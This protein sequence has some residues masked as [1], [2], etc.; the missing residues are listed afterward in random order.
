MIVKKEP[1]KT[2]SLLIAVLTITLACSGC[3]QPTVVMERNNI[4]D[5]THPEYVPGS[6]QNL[7]ISSDSSGLIYLTWDDRATL[8]DGYLVEKAFED[9]SQFEII[10]SLPPDT[11]SYTDSSRIVD[12]NTFFRISSY[13]EQGDQLRRFAHPIQK[14]TI[15]KLKRSSL[16]EIPDNQRHILSWSVESNFLNS[17]ELEI[18]QEDKPQTVISKSGLELSGEYIDNLEEIRFSDR[19][20]ILRGILETGQN[21]QIAFEELFKSDIDELYSPTNAY[22]EIINEMQLRV[23]W[24][25]RAFF[26]DKI[27][28]YKKDPSGDINLLTTLPPETKKYTDFS[29]V[30]EQNLYHIISVVGDSKSS[31]EP[32]SKAFKWESIPTASVSETNLANTNVLELSLTAEPAEIIDEFIL[33]R[34]DHQA[35]EKKEIA[36]LPGG[37]ESYRDYTIEPGLKYSYTLESSSTLALSQKSDIKDVEALLSDQFNKTK[38]YDLGY[39]G[40]AR[41]GRNLQLVNNNQYALLRTGKCNSTGEKLKIVNLHTDELHELAFPGINYINDY[42]HNPTE[43]T[44]LA[45]FSNKMTEVGF[46]GGELVREADELY[47]GND[48]LR[49]LSVQSADLHNNGRNIYVNTNNGSILNIDYESLNI[50]AIRKGGGSTTGARD[51]QLSNN[52]SLLISNDLVNYVVDPEQNEIIQ[53]FGDPV[54]ENLPVRIFFSSNDSYFYEV[55]DNL[56]LN[57][58]NSNSLDASPKRLQKVTKDGDAYPDNSSVIGGFGNSSLVVYDHSQDMYTHIRLFEAVQPDF[59]L[60]YSGFRFIDEESYILSRKDDVL[61]IWEKSGQKHW[62]LLEE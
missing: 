59:R 53:T 56:G 44:L 62:V 54:L 49:F 32:A 13:K 20:Y 29:P 9:T 26:A 39:C 33:F 46:P 47:S 10:A 14:L 23:T 34:A 35:S 50:N 15:F 38:V 1:F 2:Q 28:L 57:I 22:V 31:F 48:F 7:D 25:N 58:Y 17:L 51:I 42:F 60:L 5:P 27:E 52:N 37:T 61:E 18:Y 11:E 55:R 40:S 24:T 36:R 30:M 45:F 16:S 4:N 41:P 12:V 21:S 19:N 3:E 8:E 43:N 6:P